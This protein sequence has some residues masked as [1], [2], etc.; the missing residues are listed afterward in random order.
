M[1]S[2]IR[3][4][5]HQVARVRGPLNAAVTRERFAVLVIAAKDLGRNA[6][7]FHPSRSRVSVQSDHR[8]RSMAISRFG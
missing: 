3:T 6:C 4:S 8:F 1:S 5:E 2:R 7:A